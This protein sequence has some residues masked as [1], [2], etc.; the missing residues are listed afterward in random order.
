VRGVT[1]APACRWSNLGTFRGLL[2]LRPVLARIRHGL[3]R[4]GELTAHPAAFGLVALYAIAWLILSPGTFGWVRSQ[5]W[6]LG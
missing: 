1:P 3:T 5:H 2:A 6:R 4:I